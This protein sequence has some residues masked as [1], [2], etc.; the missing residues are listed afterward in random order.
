MYKSILAVALVAILAACS[1][2]EDR[3]GQ[4]AADTAQVET[5]SEVE[6]TFEARDE[7]TG[8]VLE[9]EQTETVNRV[10]DVRV[11]EVNPDAAELKQP[12]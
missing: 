10:D 11:D 4:P 5:A 1:Q 2:S 7:V 9:I 12:Q 3:I 8:E 6:R